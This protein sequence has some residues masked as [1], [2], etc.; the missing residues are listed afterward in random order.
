[1]TRPDTELLRVASADESDVFTVR[2]R[3]RK[4]AAAVG[5][6][7]QD[8]IRVAAALS[9]IGRD[10]VR[11][12]VPATV[13]FVLATDAPAP[14]LIEYAWQGVG[15]RQVLAAGWDAATRLMDDVRVT[16]RDGLAS[17]VM[18]KNRPSGSDAV[19]LVALR[20]QLAGRAAA[21]PLD[22]LRTQNQELL[23]T[24][25][26]LE[27]RRRELVRL[28]EELTETNRGVLALYKELSEELE[29]TNRGVVALYA[30]LNEKSTELKEASEAK[31]RFWSNISHELRGPINSVLGL[32][33]LLAAPGSDQLTDEQRHQIG[34]ITDS[35]TTLLALVNELLDT[36]KAESGRLVPQYTP[37]NLAAVFAQ[38][39][40]ALRSTVPSAD[41]EL[42][43]E[44]PAVPVLWTDETM[45]V[46]ILRNLLS[47]GLKFTEQG[48]VRLMVARDGEH[49]RFDVTDTGVGIPPDQT[50]RVFE[51][52]HQV[53]HKLQA[54]RTGTGLGLPY[55]RRLTEIL[56]GELTLSSV[57][58]QGTT[59]ALRMPT[60]DPAAT[61]VTGL[62][63]VLLVDD[64]Q[65]FREQLAAALGELATTV[66]HAADGRAALVAISRRRPDLVFLDLQMPG[67]NGREVLGVLRAKPDLADLP[68]VVVTSA[69]PGGFDLTSSGLAAALL[70]K[71]QISAESI[72]LAI[73]EAF[74]V[75]S[76]TVLR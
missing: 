61:G 15:P 36:A 1:M 29:E 5:L 75:A 21:S 26:D 6:D 63:R 62:D 46:R 68:V 17:F 67:M 60:R 2:Q 10:L 18:V 30:E 74:V 59:V 3:G 52:F 72:R 57:V 76:R 9:D 23:D 20:R 37:V 38:L 4:I 24:L 33:R 12:G 50:D 58:G 11:A 48:E 7:S 16:Y 25:G 42:A 71:S 35:G 45:L 31:T 13:T 43:I 49:V 28:N 44:Q 56:G 55:A 8:Q 32:A 41:V 14:L 64:E 27:E 22:E 53:R 66:E 34:L 39:R 65:G 51:E 40:D 69:V 73:G 70:L 47:N 19:N 54:R